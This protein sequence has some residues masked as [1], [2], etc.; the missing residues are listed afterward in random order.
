MRLALLCSLVMVWYRIFPRVGG[1]LAARHLRTLVFLNSC[2]LAW[3]LHYD[4]THA[5]RPRYFRGF[6]ASRMFPVLHMLTV[7]HSPFP[8]NLSGGIL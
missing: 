6:D 4:S 7:V 1:L 5:S 2:S 8:S 3:Q